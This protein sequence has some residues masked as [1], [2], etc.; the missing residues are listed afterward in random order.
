M[1]QKRKYECL[2][3]REEQMQ[4]PRIHFAHI[5]GT[6]NTGD[7]FCG[8]ELYFADFFSKYYQKI[9][10]FLNINYDEIF[11][12]DIVILGGGAFC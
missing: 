10:S 8:V 9:H 11:K 4:L 1:G 2:K 7:T 5:L 3:I 6:D 12:N